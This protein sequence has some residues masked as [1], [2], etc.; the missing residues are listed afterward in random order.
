L[1]ILDL[2]PLTGIEIEVVGDTIHV[3][4]SA[5]STLIVQ[6]HGSAATALHGASMTSSQMDL[7][8]FAN[9]PWMRVTVVDAAGK[10]AWSNPLWR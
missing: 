5:A 7:G 2:G 4:S 9:S 6:G 3:E 1:D 10:K 8:R